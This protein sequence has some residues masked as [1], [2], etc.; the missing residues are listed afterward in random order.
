ML[1][2]QNSL[3]TVIRMFAQ[4]NNPDEAPSLDRYDASQT[5]TLG[6]LLTL[7]DSADVEVGVLDKKTC[8]LNSYNRNGGRPHRAFSLF[9]FNHKNELL[10]QRRSHL[11]IAFPDAWTN[12]VCSHPEVREKSAGQY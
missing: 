6:D 5:S 3:Y 11:K 7:V 9:L 12:S 1:P 10:L 2:P 4:G 8:H